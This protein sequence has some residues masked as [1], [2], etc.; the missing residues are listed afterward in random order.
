MS[1][2]QFQVEVV[3]GKVIPKGEQPLP[4][5]ATGNLILD[6]DTPEDQEARSK[7]ID[8]FLK[9]FSGAFTL[10]PDEEIN[11]DPR[12]QYLVDKYHLR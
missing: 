3:D 10:P 6:T 7:A 11:A 1:T 2:L 9:E 5:E 4:K 8:E 12:L